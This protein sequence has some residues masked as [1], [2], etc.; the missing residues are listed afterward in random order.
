[1]TKAVKWFLVVFVFVACLGCF[2][3]GFSEGIEETIEFYSVTPARL[4]VGTVTV[5]AVKMEI[6]S[7]SL[8]NM[9]WYTKNWKPEEHT[10]FTAV[11]ISI[12]NSKTPTTTEGILKNLVTGS[13]KAAKYTDFEFVVDDK[14]YDVSWKD[15]KAF[16][17]TK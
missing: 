14:I 11:Q 7:Q 16:L 2:V 12:Q 10:N 5:A 8:D 4:T 17:E 1:M 9:I 15:L 13:Y 3:V 6:N